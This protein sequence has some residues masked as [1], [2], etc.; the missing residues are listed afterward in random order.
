MAAARTHQTVPHTLRRL[1]IHDLN[2][3]KEYQARIGNAG[4]R[5]YIAQK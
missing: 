2:V 1:F 5:Q 4:R 3:K